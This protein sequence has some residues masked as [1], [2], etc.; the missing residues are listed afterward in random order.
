MATV[1]FKGE[2]VELEG[3]P[4]ALNQTAPDFTVSEVGAGTAS[5][6]DFA[7]KV[8]L[9]SVVPDIDTSVCSIQSNRISDYAKQ[10][11]DGIEVVTISTNTDESLA[12]WKSDNDSTMRVFNDAV[13]F[14]KAYGVYMPEL[15]KL[16]RSMFI[17]DADGNVVYEEIVNEV[18]NEPDYEKAIQAVD[19]IAK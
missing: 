11:G 2:T 6:E 18:T 7:G 5:K 4:V 14:G 13:E 12:K 1:T 19:E 15:D 16:A 9:V 3:T 8:L 10:A 17:I